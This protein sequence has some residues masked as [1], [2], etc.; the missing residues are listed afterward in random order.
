[1]EVIVDDSQLSLAI[2]KKGQNVRLAA[3]LLGWKVDIKSEEE[4]RQEVETAMAMVVPGAPVSVLIDHGLTEKIVEK[5]IE[6]GIGTVEKLG[7]MTPE[8]LE[9]IQGI[10]PKMVERIQIS[11]NAYYG[12]FESAV[13]AAPEPEAG[14]EGVQE[15]EAGVEESAA[16]DQ[17][18]AVEAAPEPEA[19]EEGVQGP[20]AGMEEPAA[21]DLAPGEEAA[22]P[23]PANL[24]EPEVELDDS[25]AGTAESDTIKDSA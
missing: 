9:E 2:G 18:P 20:A 7:S 8:A 23:V 3:R 10:G 25:A 5:L 13:E 4:K 17:A 15:P 16:A 22:A 11:V 12:Q 14:E 6:A 21:A 24:A 1:M 19:G